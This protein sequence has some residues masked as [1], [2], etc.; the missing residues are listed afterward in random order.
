MKNGETFPKNRALGDSQR[1][2]FFADNDHL[3][4]TL[5]EKTG[6]DACEIRRRAL[7]VGLPLLA[8]LLGTK[9]TR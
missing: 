1:V 8:E 6:L 4:A 5:K 2:R 9:G 3:I 7:H